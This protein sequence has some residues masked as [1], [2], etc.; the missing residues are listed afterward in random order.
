LLTQLRSEQAVLVVLL[1]T[2]TERKA[3]ILLLLDLLLQLVVVMVEIKTQTQLVVQVVQAVAVLTQQEA[4]EHLVKVL[5]A[6][7]GQCKAQ[8]AAVAQAL[9]VATLAAQ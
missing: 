2:T 3:Q 1:E 4:L 8:V 5:Q 7:L 9:L 6:V